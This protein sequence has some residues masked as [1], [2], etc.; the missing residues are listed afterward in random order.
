MSVETKPAPL[1]H[2]SS[3]LRLNAVVKQPRQTVL[4]SG[5]PNVGK[6]DTA[7]W[8]AEQIVGPRWQTQ[9]LMIDSG[10]KGN[11]FIEE[12][13]KIRHFSQYKSANSTDRKVVIIDNAHTMG[14]EAQ[15][16]FL[17]LLEEPPADLY[18]ILLSWQPN[19]LLETIRSRIVSIDM[20]PPSFDQ[21]AEH[22]ADLDIHTLKRLYLMTNGSVNL[23]EQLSGEDEHIYA[24]TIKQAKTLVGQSAYERLLRVDEMS[25]DKIATEE[26]L[27]AVTI[28]LLSALNGFAEQGKSIKSLLPKLDAVLAARSSLRKNH[29]TKLTLTL[30][31]TSL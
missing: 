19:K 8:L 20:Q 10:E 13:Q 6:L 12:I 29:N 3:L 9:A 15:N 27:S 21:V 16:S 23:I 11:I 2:P 1:L 7:K 17:K 31:F 22:F 26:L 18:M 5:P 14:L 4:L 28:I 30:L 25:K 24:Q